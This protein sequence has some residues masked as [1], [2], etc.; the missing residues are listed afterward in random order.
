MYKF[1]KLAGPF[2]IGKNFWDENYQVSLLDP[3]KKLYER[4]TSKDKSISSKEMWSLWLYLDPSVDN[5][6]YRQPDHQKKSAIMS[7]FPEFNFKDP[8]I[9]ECILAY[10]DSCM[11]EAKRAYDREIRGLRKFTEMIDEMMGQELTI[12][13]Y[14]TVRNN[15]GTEQ[16]KL[17]K[18]TAKQVLEL[19]EK[20]VKLFAQYE[21]VQSIFNEEEAQVILY[22]GGELSLV[23]EGGL[24]E[25]DDEEYE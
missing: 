9:A 14:V 10:P 17:I 6:L 7:Y 25:L 16:E 22:G 8:V 13:T 23:E 18:G 5:K 4:D 12:D 19:K 3:F 20:A 2:D 11:S 21:K 24:M 1:V 15:R